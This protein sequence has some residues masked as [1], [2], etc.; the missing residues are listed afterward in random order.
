MAMRVVALV[1]L[2]I[3]PLAAQ[4]PS[5][6]DLFERARLLEESSRSLEEAIALYGKVA[7]ESRERVAAT[8]SR[9]ARRTHLR[10]RAA[11]ERASGGR[12]LGAR[13]P[14]VHLPHSRRA[15][16]RGPSV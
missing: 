13:H 5:P 6:R 12:V 2:L 3:V 15:R 14:P 11:C 4:A 10:T 7:A 1:T 8:W 16:E 9:V